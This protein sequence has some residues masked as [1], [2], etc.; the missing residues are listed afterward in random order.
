MTV[1]FWDIDGT[2]LSTARAGVFAWEDAVRELTGREF[3]LARMRIAG[4]TDYQIARTFEAL[5]IELTRVCT[6]V[7]RYAS[8]LAS[9]GSRA[10]DAQREIGP[11]R[12]P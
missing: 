5:G 12:P 3:E 4:L 11:C 6:F 2:L 10:G 7:D 8:S 9:G 1:L